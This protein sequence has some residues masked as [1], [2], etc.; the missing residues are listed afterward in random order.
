MSDFVR[1]NGTKIGFD[2]NSWCILSPIEQS[3]KRKIEAVGIPLKDW[4]ISI[5]YGIKTGC[6]E[7]FIIDGE[8][9]DALIAQDPKSAEIIRPILRG[10]DIKRYSY[11]FADKWLIATFPSKHYNIDDYPAIKNYLLSFGKEK[12]EQ[13]GKKDIGGIKGNNARKK[14]NNKWFETQDTIA[15]WD[16]F[17]KQKLVWTPVNSEYRFTILPPDIFFNNSLFMITG[18][19][20]KYLCAILNSNLF[21]FYLNLILGGENYTYGSGNV[22]GSIPIKPPLPEEETKIDVLVESAL[23]GNLSAQTSINQYVYKIFQ[24]SNDEQLYIENSSSVK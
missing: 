4:N 22:F 10:R 15:Y 21:I 20:I 16:D 17:S 7:A 24:L 3:I 8:T 14:T 6:N 9:K 18:K 19:S 23:V 2:R 11:D 1:Q 13:S 12:L 5:N